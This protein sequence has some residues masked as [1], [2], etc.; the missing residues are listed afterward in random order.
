ML[1]LINSM[2]DKMACINSR[3]PGRERTALHIACQKGHAGTARALIQ[4][5]A[6]IHA[7]VSEEKRTAL[8]LAAEYGHAEVVA[9]LLDARAGLHAQSNGL[10]PLHLAAQNDHILAAR[11]LLTSRADV[12]AR[13]VTRSCWWCECDVTP[14][15][16]AVSI[17][18]AATVSFLLEERASPSAVKH[19]HCGADLT[20][21]HV[22]AQHGNAAAA[23]ALLAA[24]ADPDAAADLSA[25]ETA[26]EGCAGVTPLHLACRTTYGG[27]HRSGPDGAAGVVRALLA[28]RA[29]AS[30]EIDDARERRDGWTALQCA[31]EAVRVGGFGTRSAD[32]E[33]LDALRAGILAGALHSIGG[34]AAA[35]LAAAAEAV[36]SRDRPDTRG[37]RRRQLWEVLRAASGGDCVGGSAVGLRRA[38]RTARKGQRGGRLAG[39]GQIGLLW[40]W[41][42]EL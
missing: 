18:S 25:S 35:W 16:L 41:A 23:C 4:A 34:A 33:A 2:E 19:G 11:V 17:G 26:W 30:A 20:P 27:W 42:A 12:N 21:L 36:G 13:A 29:D 14:L 22:A 9:V 38:R 28:A 6:D 40:G 7:L 39:S 5:N 3:E 24:G 8:H 37:E 31:M 32:S 10:T 15:H 1:A